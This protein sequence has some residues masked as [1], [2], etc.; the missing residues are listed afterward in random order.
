LTAQSPEHGIP[1]LLFL[2]SATGLAAPIESVS[3]FRPDN[4]PG[5]FSELREKK[6]F[7]LQGALD[8]KLE[9]GST[10]FRCRFTTP[11]E[12]KIGEESTA[13]SSCKFHALRGGKMASGKGA[14]MN[15]M[16]Y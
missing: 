13:T 5:N 8:E 9:H 1:G 7:F 15:R 16:L 2:R 4:E 6:N 3:F 10:F 14:S 11:K 12:I